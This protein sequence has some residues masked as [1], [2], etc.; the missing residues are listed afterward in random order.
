MSHASLIPKK[1]TDND[2]Q[3]R[4][5]R[6]WRLQLELYH[7]LLHDDGMLHNIHQSLPPDC[8]ASMVH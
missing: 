8:Y 2:G 4:L 1:D 7:H 3:T 5:H 6:T